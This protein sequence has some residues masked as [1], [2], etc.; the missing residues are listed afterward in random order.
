M[1]KPLK[2]CITS[3]APFIAGA[4]V[5]AERLALGLQG[6][7]HDVLVVVGTDGDAI[8]RFRDNGLRCEYVEQR[9]TDK[10]TWFKYR[11]SRVA[12]TR[13]LDK[14]TPDLVHSNDLPTHQMTSDAARRLGIPRV[15]HHRWIFDRKAIDWLNKHGAEQ[16]LFVSD[17]LMT[18]LCGESSELEASRR[19]VLYDGLPIPAMPQEQDRADAKSELNLDSSRVTVLYAGQ[20]IERKGVADLLHAWNLLQQE[21]RDKSQLIIVGDDLENEGDY[22][23]QMEQL[24]SELGNPVPFMGFQSNVPTWLRAADVV[25]VPSH[26]EPLGNATLE[27][28]AHGRPVIGCDVGGIPEMVRHEQTGIIVAPKSPSELAAAIKV[29]INNPELRDR[30]GL[31]ARKQCEDRFSLKRH[32]D[33]ALEH[34]E[35]VLSTRDQS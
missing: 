35:R 24:A 28:M 14:E 26:A 34:Y 12:L 31:E 22:R 2:I 8:T 4:E 15:C 6:D 25:M 23:R 3:W 19:A 17:A 29:L 7:G 13:L 16:H 32:V 5:A 11:H 18:M 27:A 33:S 21:L 10:L 20:I 30:Y 9:F 1:S